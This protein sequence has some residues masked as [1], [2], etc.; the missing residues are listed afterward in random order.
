[1]DGVDVAACYL[2][3]TLQLRLAAV[4]PERLIQC[5]T[6]SK[7]IEQTFLRTQYLSFPKRYTLIM[8]NTGACPK[9]YRGNPQV[10]YIEHTV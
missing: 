8:R 2:F 3:P 5:Q 7:S 4:L 1:M 6:V 10:D 9:V